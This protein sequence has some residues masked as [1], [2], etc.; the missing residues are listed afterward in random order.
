MC[1]P[2]S[3]SFFFSLCLLPARRIWVVYV[4]STY[5]SCDVC[6]G[7]NESSVS[8]VFVVCLLKKKWLKHR[9]TMHKYLHTHDGICC[10]FLT[11]IDNI[12]CECGSRS[13]ATSILHSSYVMILTFRF[14][15]CCCCCFLL[16]ARRSDFHLPLELNDSHT[17]EV[18]TKERKKVGTEIDAILFIRYCFRL[19]FTFQSI[20]YCRILL[21]FYCKIASF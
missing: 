18:E 7:T 10:N 2:D 21:D 19:F 11:F 1:I 8:L 14:V 20:I 13:C 17:H 5:Y 3:V 16:T 4:D 12:R 15:C 6:D 9:N